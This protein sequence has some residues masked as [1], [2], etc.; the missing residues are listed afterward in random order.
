IIMMDSDIYIQSYA[1]SII[2][3]LVPG[4]DIYI[5]KPYKRPNSG[6]MLFRNN[7]KSKKFIQDVLADKNNMVDSIDFV[8]PFG[9]NGHIIKHCRLNE[10][11]VEIISN[12]WNNN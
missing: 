2:N 8:T 10:S 5:A 11:L 4:K 7:D 6:V 9:E 1:P 12:R 3:L